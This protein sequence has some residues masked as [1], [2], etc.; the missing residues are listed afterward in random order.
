MS[1]G[2]RLTRWFSAQRAIRA[3]YY[4]GG[5][6]RGVMF[7]DADLPPDEATRDRIF[8]QVMDSPDPN[9]RQLDGFGGGIT[10][11]SK[12]CV[13]S[14]R[15]EDPRADVSFAFA[16]VGIESP[17]VD[18]TSNCGNMSA[19]VGPFAFNA[20]LL[21]N[22]F[23]YDQPRD[24]TVRIFNTNTNKY[25]HSTFPVADGEAMAHGSL[26]I[27]GVAGSGAP[28]KL[29]FIDPAGAK[30]GKLLPTGNVLDTVDGIKVTCIDVTN[31]NVFVSAEDVGL[32]GDILPDG[33]NTL[34]GKLEM[35]DNLRRKAAVKMG[36]AESAELVP[37]SIPDRHR[38]AA[39]SAHAAV[40]QDA[41]GERGGR[42]GALHLGRPAAPRHPTH[43]CTVHRRGR[44]AAWFDRARATG[45]AARRQGH[46]HHRTPEWTHPSGRRHG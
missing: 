27:D 39:L 25:I 13:V 37:R 4:R 36:I 28:I 35:L 43:R 29:E 3:G 30:T 5:T 24:V 16:N 46:G 6:S 34:P 8:L 15:E 23:D 17:V 26:A 2:V 41:G 21:G 7:V 9:G 40:G 44:Q 14:P 10:S 32:P 22:E 42:G 20:Q 45:G 19:A 38:L 1:L 12:V 18:R 11:L 33:I 31:P